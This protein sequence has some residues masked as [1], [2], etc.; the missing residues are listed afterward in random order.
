KADAPRSF[1]AGQ[2]LL[3]EP[4]RLISTLLIGNE[5]VNA[6]V[7]VI[8]SS[9]VYKFAE[10]RVADKYLPVLAVA[11]VLPFLLI[12]G[13]I[14]PK[15]MGVKHPEGL[16]SRVAVPLDWFSRFVGPL[17]DVLSWI[18]EQVLAFTGG[19]ERGPLR[20]SEDVFRS[21]VDT[22]TEEGVL[23]PNERR[24]IHNVFRMDD[25]RVS[26]VMTPKSGVSFLREAM[27]LAE[28][29]GRF[30]SE[31]YSRYPVTDAQGEKITGILY[32]KDLI[33]VEAWDAKKPWTACVRPPLHVESDTNCLELF[34][35][36]RSRR[37]HFAIVQAPQTGDMLGVVTLDDVL[38]VVFGELR[39]QYDGEE[40]LPSKP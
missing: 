6:A 21:M 2:R 40:A 3:R 8:G 5:L 13:E 25:I 14:I 20:V 37:T 33:G 19:T 28:V 23:D 24:L 11:S 35:R 22:G 26:Q 10:G 4:T 15:T 12:F 17:R 29:V 38:R 34:L 7:G 27:T 1:A 36:F 32:V 9:L 30:E 39:D 18:S 16:A 31:K